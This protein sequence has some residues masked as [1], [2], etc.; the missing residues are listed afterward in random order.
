MFTDITEPI[1]DD[2]DSSLS[3][4]DPKC[5]PL[6]KW[7]G[8]TIIKPNSEEA[9]KMSG[10]TEWRKQADYF[11]DET[12]CT[13]VVITQA[14]HGVVGKIGY[15]GYF[16]YY[17]EYEVMAD[18]VVGAG[19]CFVAF[20]A[21]CMSHQMDLYDAI[22][23]AFD[24]GRIYVQRRHNKPVSVSELQKFSE[25]IESKFVTAEY[26]ADRDYKLVFTNG[27]FDIMHA[28]HLETLAFAK[29][30]GE[31]LVVAV[32]SDE[33]VKKSKGENRPIIGCNDR[34]KLLAA[35][36]CVDFVLEFS[37][38]TPYNLIKKIEPDVLVKGLDWEGD[39]VGSDIV[40]EVHL[41]PFV[42]GLSTTNIVEKIK[43]S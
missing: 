38:K 39:V 31:K 32:N 30:K 26:L 8:C 23:V 33:T 36:E 13:A 25:P 22:K 2:L 37:E 14:G 29:S 6:S 9:E 17:P 15:D 11:Q 10:E 40:K 34:M 1:I 43:E 41:A 24:A 28:G 42:E 27:V 12:D 19:D 3:I 35:L 7:K 18:S 4:V 21:M 16:E 20:L 5:G